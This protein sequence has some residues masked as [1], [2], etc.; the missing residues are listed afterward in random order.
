MR[1]RGILIKPIALQVRIIA[2]FIDH[3]G[4]SSSAL[5]YHVVGYICHSH[6]SAGWIQGLKV[7]AWTIS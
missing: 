1:W 3:T 5:I 6:M 7:H 2:I 4:L